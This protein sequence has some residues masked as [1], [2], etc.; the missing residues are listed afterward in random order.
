MYLYIYICI[1]IYIYI[2]IYISES[3]TQNRWVS[4]DE[5]KRAPA[6]L[7]LLST[8]RLGLLPLHTLASKVPS[9]CRP[10]TRNV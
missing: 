4:H 1:Y 9:S 3:E 2:C 6:L 10:S 8:V 7:P 5:A